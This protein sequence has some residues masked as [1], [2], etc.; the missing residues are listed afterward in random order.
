[1]RHTARPRRSLSLS[2]SMREEDDDGG[3]RELNNARVCGQMVS[4]Y[5]PLAVTYATGG[6]PLEF[7]RGDYDRFAMHSPIDPD[8]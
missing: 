5:A 8:A 1:M 7:L 6:S 2:L 3:G 4:H